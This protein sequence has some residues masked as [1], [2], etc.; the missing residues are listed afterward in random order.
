MQDIVYVIDRAG[1]GPLLGYT[2]EKY[3]RM[4]KALK[5]AGYRVAKIEEIKKFK[6]IEVVP[7]SSKSTKKDKK[8]EHVEPTTPLA[9][10][11]L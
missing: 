10:D 3:A 4:E 1:K 11:A 7:E 5:N 9:D 6:D 8:E 2:A